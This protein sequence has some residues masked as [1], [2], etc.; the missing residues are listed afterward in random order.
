M[1]ETEIKLRWPGDAASARAHIEAQGYIASG[2]RLLEADQLFDRVSGDRTLADPEAG[3]LRA[4]GRV[5]R[6]RISGGKATV[7][8]KGPVATQPEAGP[9]KSREE[10][11]FDVD[12]PVAFELVL[13]RLG[14]Q[15]GFRYEKFRTK[16]AMPDEL[17]PRHDG[18]IVTLDET[19]IAIFMELEGPEYWIDAAAQRLGF[20]RDRFLSA[21]YAA[22]YREFLETHPHAPTD[23]VFLAAS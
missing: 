5:L 16:F 7:T 12:D 15:R 11:E 20:A 3:E 13:S 22:L 1:I 9:Y 2:P 19:P 4:S 17:A 8:Y 18:G 6:L 23:M 10:I 21:S 14:Y